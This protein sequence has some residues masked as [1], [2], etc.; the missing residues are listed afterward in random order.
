MTA[1]N[2]LIIGGTRNLGHTLTLQLLAAGHRVTLLNRGQTPDELPAGLPRLRADRSDPAQ[3]AQALAGRDF[4]VVIDTTLYNGPDAA[5]VVELLAGRVGQYIFISTG[6]VYLV[7]LGVERPFREADYA[8]PVMAAPAPDS[9]DYHEWLYGFEKRQAED[10]LTAAWQ[11]RGFPFVSLRLPMVNSERDHFKRIY[12]YLLRLQDGGPILL[13]AGPALSLRHVYGGDV[14]Q[15]IMRVID[16]GVH[17]GQAFNI[18]QD[19]TISLED[20]LA[21][22]AELAG[23]PLRTVAVP[24][25]ALVVRQ[26]LPACSPFS[27]PWMS[28]L[29]N[30]LGKEALGLEYTPLPVYLQKLVTHYQTHSVP[31][32]ESYQWRA[33]ELELAKSYT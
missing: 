17:Q 25:E 11:N 30:R 24:R 16:Q 21:M 18:S 14:V 6:Q 15:A 5:A 7:R 8:G 33:V 19:E 13:P 29:D 28:A 4:E 31:P 9:D 26:L 12:N 22:L 27:D 23:R 1:K 2:I 3:L 20:F 32:P 10:V